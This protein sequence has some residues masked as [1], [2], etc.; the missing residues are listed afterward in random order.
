[1]TLLVAVMIG[2][3]ITVAA[4]LVIRLSALDGGGRAPE[5]VADPIPPQI[6]A[7]IA[8]EALVLPEGA[9]ITAIGRSGTEILVATE[10]PEGEVLRVF[11]AG[12]GRAVSA[13]PIR[14][15]ESVPDSQ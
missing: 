5:P 7:P 12:T 3:V 4:T 8:A 11:D 15:D 6:P 14:R 2:G 13:T 1:V 9:R 10:G